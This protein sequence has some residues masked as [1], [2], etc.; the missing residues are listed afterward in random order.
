MIL[1][2]HTDGC[3]LCEQAEALLQQLGVAFER[4]DIIHDERLR[5]TYGWRIPVI[6]SAGGELDWPFDRQRLEHFLTIYHSEPI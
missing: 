6:A 1:L 2:Y 5:A 3:H 4:S